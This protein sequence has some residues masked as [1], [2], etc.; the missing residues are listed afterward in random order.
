MLQHR[1]SG[2]D[3]ISEK[4]EL[5]SSKLAGD[6]DKHPVILRRILVWGSGTDQKSRCRVKT[7]SSEVRF[8]RTCGHAWITA[9]QMR[10]FDQAFRIV[11]M[12][13]FGFETLRGKVIINRRQPRRFRVSPGGDLDRSKPHARQLDSHRVHANLG[14]YDNVWMLF[15]YRFDALLQ[16][17]SSLAKRGSV[18]PGESRL[19]ILRRSQIKQMED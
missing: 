5:A 19:I 15:K 9:T 4:Y 1:R 18:D 8:F 14:V 16:P 2:I 10:E 17:P 3:S 6:F 12:G 13:I 7:Q 11:R